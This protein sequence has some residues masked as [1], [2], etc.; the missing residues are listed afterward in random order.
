MILEK[1]V[2]G[3]KVIAKTGQGEIHGYGKIIA[4][5][6]EPMACIEKE[7]G[8]RFWWNGYLCQLDITHD[9]QIGPRSLSSWQE[10]YY[11]RHS[12][13]NIPAHDVLV[14][15]LVKTSAS[16]ELEYFFARYVGDGQFKIETQAQLQDDGSRR[17]LTS[18]CHASFVTHWQYVNLP[19]ET[20]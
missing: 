4:Y 1:G 14:A 18:T 15:I 2:M 20:Q 16:S 5:S 17:K 13:Q 6:L 9:E 7:D 8:E 11:S 10:L 3:R 19:T 12:E